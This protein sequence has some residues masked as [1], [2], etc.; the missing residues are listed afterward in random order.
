MKFTRILILC[1]VLGLL[2]TGCGAMS[3]E[4]P[5]SA[6]DSSLAG[7]AN[8]SEQ[9]ADKETGSTQMSDPVNQK[10]I[11]KVWLEAETEDMD[12][13][14]VSVE[15]RIR[16]LG[17]YVEARQIHNG[18]KYDGYGY[19][20]GELTVRIP[21]DMLYSFVDHVSGASNITSTRE[22]S[23]DVTLR[24]VEQESKVTA[25]ETEQ[26]RLLELLA[27]ASTM[28]DVLK[29]ESRLT[30]IRE[31]LEQVKSQLRLYDNLV[32]YGTVYLSIS[33]VR[34]YTVTQEP[35]VTLWDRMTRQI[36]N[37]WE[38][39]VDGLE[40]CLVFLFAALPHLLPWAV[41]GGIVVTVV[42]LHK[43]KKKQ[44]TSPEKQDHAQ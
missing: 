5:G 38:D 7:S 14:L 16:D 9:L 10:L 21:A 37:S 39:M 33:E 41:I 17:G 24:Y 28:E 1:M 18:S 8:G 26:N 3:N 22:T 12:A 20:Y 34:E 25:L 2:L 6:A 23:E 40:D 27:E 44:K 31:Q 13:L 30:T 42:V 36:S 4:S 11:R 19:R 35:P 29:I 32:S 43:K 15:E